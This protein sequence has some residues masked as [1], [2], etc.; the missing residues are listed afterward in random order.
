MS[1]RSSVRSPLALTA[2]PMVRSSVTA[3]T[4]RRTWFVCP[5][6]CLD[7]SAWCLSATRWRAPPAPTA[8]TPSQAWMSSSRMAKPIPR[9]AP[10]PAAPS[11]F[12]RLFA[13]LKNS[14]EGFFYDSN[15]L[16]YFVNHHIS[17]PLM[18]INCFIGIVSVVI[19]IIISTSKK[20]NR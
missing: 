20:H 15:H 1:L 5:T 19:G 16:Q 10:L 7:I 3:S 13:I 11:V 2:T 8:I 18:L 14:L 12:S 6:A 17:F 4:S 9:T